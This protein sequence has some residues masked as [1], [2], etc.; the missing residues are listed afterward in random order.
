MVTK[1]FLTYGYPKDDKEGLSRLLSEALGI[2]FHIASAESYTYRFGELA[3]T[4]SVFNNFMDFDEEWTQPDF[5]HCPILLTASFTIGKNI[6]KQ[7]K[8]EHVKNILR[9][10]PDLIEIKHTIY[11]E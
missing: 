11:E 8:A 10:I 2:E 3:E 9:L 7:A 5:Q 1:H 4:I 6:D